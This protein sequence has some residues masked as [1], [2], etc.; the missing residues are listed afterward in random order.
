MGR[1]QALREFG[2]TDNEVRVYI[3]ALELGSAP[4]QAVAR[5]AG[6][7][8]TTTYEILRGFITK[9]VASSVTHKNR[10]HFE[11]AS[12]HLLLDLMR[13]REE[14][15]K[16]VLP[17]LLALEK[18]VVKKPL[19]E[20]Y[21]GKEGVKTILKDLLETAGEE[22][23]VIGNNKKFRDVFPIYSKSFT[24]RRYERGIK[25]RYLAEPSPVTASIKKFDQEQNR[26][27]RVAEGLGDVDAEALIYSG[28]VAILTLMQG[29]MLAV[30][31]KEETIA[32]FFRTLFE[33][34]WSRT[35]PD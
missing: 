12:P 10:S 28:N 17:E 9:G 6:L 26:E 31:I 4:A 2:F 35:S 13:E 29:E 5:R 24:K 1:H 25:C 30:L 20:F 33:T 18:S 32:R 34:M 11:V 22:Y 23:M 19:V 16:A 21:E 8:R 14:R 15:L 7:L 27:I 3:A